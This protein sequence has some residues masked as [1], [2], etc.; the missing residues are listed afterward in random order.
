MT[1]KETKT[2]SIMA[3]FATLKSLSDAKQYQSPYQILSEFINHIILS[4][5]LYSFSA[6][7]MK[8]R[9]NSHFCFSI[10]EAVVKTSLKNV[11]GAILADGIYTISKTEVCTDELFEEAKKESDEY[12]TRI[13]QLLS[14]YISVRTGNT[15]I[16]AEALSKELACFLVDDES[17]HS[18]KYSELI[19]EFVLKNEQ[20]KEIQEGLN[21]IREGSILYIGL[22]H[23][24]GETGSI[25]KPLTLYLGTEVLFSLVGYNGE[26]FQQF[27]DDFFAQVRTANSGKTK[28]ITLHYFSEIKKEIDDFFGTAS[29][30]VEGKRHRLLDKPAMKA[31][32]DGCH[33]AA[34][35]DVKKSDFYHKLQYAFGITED[36]QDNY[37]GE[38]NFTS[39]LESFDYDD[40]DDKKKK[41]ETAVKFISHINKLRNGIRFHS[42]IESEYIIVTNT[43]ATLL[44]SQ[45]L[46]EEIKA[47]EGLDKIC[48]FAISLDRITSLLWYKLGNGFS[49]N[50]YPSSVNAALKARIV[51]S[52]SIARNAE[53]EFAKIKKEYADGLID[54]D[55]ATSRIITL[56]NKPVLPED[57]QGDDIDEIMDFTPEY[58]SRYEEQ[59]K[60]N[61][62]DLKEK[63]EVIENLKA[64]SEKKLS[65]KD[66]TIATQANVIKNSSEENAQLRDELNKYHQKEA[67][68]LRKKNR[69]R[70]ILRF[71][72]SIVWKLGV[73]IGLTAFAIYL[74]SKCNS[75]IPMY[76][77]MV[78]NAVGAIYT[79]WSALKRD[80]EKYLKNNSET[81]TSDN[82]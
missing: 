71:I 2:T 80:K 13:I 58:L 64:D 26:I 40:E 53:R 52:A 66:E 69:R 19:G 82:L 75:K 57:L 7:E 3:S 59:V 25:T 38:E 73:L 22:S 72:W 14:E 31:I 8:N 1:L 61:Q 74:E 12:E 55:Q 79:L 43:K 48:N 47:N 11:S 21:K 51:L 56:R 9:L 70:N 30:I 76:I 78:V 27:A 5:S 6:V 28:K 4:D 77:S 18:T 44:I 42:D 62:K 34:D 49:K 65:E 16:S 50:D 37:Y 45:E 36:P 54:D 35:V 33:T 60:K 20:N 39:N 68:A 15:M 41:K 29:E 63:E 10:P 81:V 46:S 32:T 67:A 24:I 23:S 17:L